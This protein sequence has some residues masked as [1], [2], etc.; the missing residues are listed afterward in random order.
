MPRKGETVDAGE[1]WPGPD[2]SEAGQVPAWEAQRWWATL[3]GNLVRVFLVSLTRKQVR[4]PTCLKPMRAA[5]GA[6]YIA[7]RRLVN[8]EARTAEEKRKL[9]EAQEATRE[10]E[11]QERIE[12]HAAGLEPTIE[13]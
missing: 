10:R 2:L 9:H 6:A 3:G 4:C 12:A 1:L 7:A 8:Q 11:E 13:G 5:D